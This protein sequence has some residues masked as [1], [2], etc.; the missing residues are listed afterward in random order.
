MAGMPLTRP[1]PCPGSS[2]QEEGAWSQQWSAEHGRPYYV[3]ERTGAKAWA[4]PAGAAQTP[5][6]QALR[7]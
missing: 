2:G 5:P 6:A 1:G 4:P 7:L 3:N